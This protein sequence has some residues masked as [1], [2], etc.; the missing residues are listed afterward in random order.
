[1]TELWRERFVD[2]WNEALSDHLDKYFPKDNIDDTSK[3]SISRRAQA[4][5]FNALA[6]RFA[7]DFI[8]DQRAEH[9]RE[10]I[11][12]SIEGVEEFAESLKKEL[13]KPTG[14]GRYLIPIIDDT[15]R[16]TKGGKDGN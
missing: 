16:N 4:L 2:K 5:A 7:L 8:Q 13:S 9:T 14:G 1:M 12:A 11:E 6:C 3:P 10:L 15:L